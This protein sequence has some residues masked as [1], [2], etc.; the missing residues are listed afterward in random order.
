MSEREQRSAKKE[1]SEESEKDLSDAATKSGCEHDSD[2]FGRKKGDLI[3]YFR[4]IS[5]I[6]CAERTTSPG[7]PS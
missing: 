2:K 6:I 7:F 1:A 4:D 5:S 3:N